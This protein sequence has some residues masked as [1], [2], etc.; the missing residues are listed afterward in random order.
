MVVVVLTGA[1]T[2]VLVV[3]VVGIGDVVG[4]VEV[5]ESVVVDVVVGG[6]SVGAC[7][8]N[9]TGARGPPSTYTGVP[10]AT[11]VW[12][13]CAAAIVI[14]TQPCDAGYTGTDGAPWIA[15]PPLK[16]SGL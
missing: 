6:A 15:I 5:D 10:L 4:V 2:V 8:L 7:S 9:G 16:Y 3:L 14:R 1:G 13:H 12:N 11:E